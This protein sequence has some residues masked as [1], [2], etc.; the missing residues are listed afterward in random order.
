M[1]TATLSVVIEF[2][3]GWIAAVLI[4]VRM[5]F[6]LPE[7]AVAQESYCPKS[8]SVTQTIEKVP[9]GWS[10]G[11]DEFAST[12]AGIAFYSGPPKEKALLKYDRWT[13]RNGLAYGVW[14]FQP[15]SSYRI[16]LSCRYSFTRVV[17]AKQLPADTTEC[18]V[19]YDPKVLVAGSP[20][21][22]TITCH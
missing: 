3:V 10:A 13:K 12:L 5:F 9:E 16:W 8:I 21:I 20:G 7:S 2:Y 22:R 18:T 4:L 17:L 6:A 1:L 19:T 11:Q 15:K 14:H